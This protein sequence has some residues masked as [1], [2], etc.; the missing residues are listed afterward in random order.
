MTD[1]HHAEDRDRKRKRRRY[2]Q[3]TTNPGMRIVMRDLA[4]KDKDAHHAPQVSPAS[5]PNSKR[6]RIKRRRKKQH[7]K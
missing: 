5:S 7:H 1:D 3:T 6:V 4:Q 2:G